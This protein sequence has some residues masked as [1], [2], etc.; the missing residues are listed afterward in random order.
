[1]TTG[2][3]D[4]DPFGDADGTPKRGLVKRLTALEEFLKQSERIPFPPGSS[5]NLHAGLQHPHSP[6]YPDEH[7]PWWR[8]LSTVAWRSPSPLWSSSTPAIHADHPKASRGAQ[9]RLAHRRHPQ[10]APGATFYRIG[11]GTVGNG[12]PI[13]NNPSSCNP[14]TAGNRS[15]NLA[16]PQKN[17][18]DAAIQRIARP[19]GTT[20]I[21]RAPGRV[22]P[23]SDSST[24][25]CSAGP[26][27][28][29]KS[30]APA[31]DRASRTSR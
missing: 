14:I 27:A 3:R 16:S 6:E 8:P 7:A 4:A 13:T 29:G 26:A 24:T 17:S 2:S 19:A 28:R 9:L 18:I 30:A 25:S 31:I 21:L 22:P 23:S 10:N 11:G 5:A 12:T 20:N 1:M 15:G